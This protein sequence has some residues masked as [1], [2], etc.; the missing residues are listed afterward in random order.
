MT[1]IVFLNLPV[2]DKELYGNFAVSAS[3]E[4][5]L[6]LC[7]L[8]AVTRAKG[9]KTKIID[10]KV[11]G[12]NFKQAAEKI[13]N[14]KPQFVG[15][16]AVTLSIVAARKFAKLLKQNDP[17]LKIILGGPHITALPKETMEYSDA[18][19]V[20]VIGEGEATIIEL[21]DALRQKVPLEGV[22]GI[23]YRNNGKIAITSPRQMINDLDILP[24]PAWDLLPR[25]DRHYFPPPPSLYRLPSFSIIT[26][27]GCPYNCIFCD[28]SAFGNKI[29][30]HSPDYVLRMIKDLYNNYNIR[31]LRINDDNFVLLRQNVFEICRLLKEEKLDLSFCCLS[32]VQVINEETARALK[33]A[34]CWQLRFGLE[35]GSQR[36]LDNIQ[37]CANLNQARRAIG[38]THDSGIESYGFF[39]IANP[40][41][42]KE[43]I[44]ETID[45]AKSLPLDVFKLNFLTPLPGCNLWNNAEEYGTFNRS[46]EKLSFHIEPMFI[47]YGLTKEE[48]V[49]YKKVAFREF[50][51]RPKIIFLYLK[52]L[53]NKWQILRL[54]KGAFSLFI[55]WRRK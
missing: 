49:Q 34:G 38:L 19:D 35:S 54:L 52:K 45:F 14:Y 30:S 20:G 3:H 6:G 24:M 27:R 5:P 48:I 42:T 11:E 55:Y 15:I 28:K 51:L 12:L 16:T 1:D 2:S 21:L 10:A 22:S 41:E 33:G 8:A 31:D 50:Y 44:R 47:P 39:M 29:R 25:L 9:Y 32:S 46:W 37:K 17:G 36:I 23:V 4:P 13:I 26:S 40:G 18:F 53:K 43:T 7:Y